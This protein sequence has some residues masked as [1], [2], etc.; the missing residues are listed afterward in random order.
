MQNVAAAEN[1]SIEMSGDAWRLLYQDLRGS[2][3]LLSVGPDGVF[4]YPAAFAETRRLPASGTLAGNHVVHV[5]LGWSPGDEAWHLG[6]LL[7]PPLAALRDSR[8]CEL[9]HW[10]DPDQEDFRELAELSGQSLSTVTGRPF[11]LIEPEAPATTRAERE[12][13]FEE[14]VPDPEEVPLPRLPLNFSDGWV[15]ERGT[16]GM[17]QLV[18]DPGAARSA[19]RRILWYALWAIVFIALIAG[20]HVSG[21]AQPARP[22]NLPHPLTLPLLA[23]LSALV[24][25]ALIVRNLVAQRNAADILIFDSYQRQIRARH[26]NRVLWSRR[27]EQIQSIY[28]TELFRKRG[29]ASARP[30]YA[31]LNLHLSS[32]RYHHLLQ[33][34]EPRQISREPVAV[35]P[36]VSELRSWHCSTNTQAVALHLAQS[37]D[38]PVW[39][40]RRIS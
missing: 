4:R 8:W 29:V 25:L 27:T 28:V 12:P 38:L 2:M 9:A 33:S 40:D 10:P 21:I 34:R 20:N 1:L 7:S 14:I 15:L 26:G 3:E 5:L 6:L 24:L 22:F 36:G 35:D 18:R 19:W 31:E 23:S 11:R 30:F 39:L 13:V 16:T 32:N 17:L 37:L